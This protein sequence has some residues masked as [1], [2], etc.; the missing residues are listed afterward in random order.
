VI[1]R[2]ID[3]ATGNKLWVILLVAAASLG[4]YWSLRR[5]PV[6]ALPDLSDTQVVG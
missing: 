1:N 6:D 2:I 4:G 3:L 5:I